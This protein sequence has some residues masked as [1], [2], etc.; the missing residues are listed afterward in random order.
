MERFRSDA[1]AEGDC[2]VIGGWE[3]RTALGITVDQ[4]DARWF[5]VELNRKNAPWA[6]RRGEPFRVIA[7]LELLGSLLSTVLFLGG[8]DGSDW[9]SGTISAG[10][11]TDNQGNRFVLNRM[12]TTKFP[13]LAFLCEFAT[14]LEE[15]G[16]VLDLAWVPRDQNA[17]ADAITNG[18]VEAFRPEN[19][20]HVDIEQMRFNV[21]TE[22][23]EL[24]D[25]FYEALEKDKA[26][27]K[28]AAE[29]E[30]RPRDE[31]AARQ[32]GGRQDG[33][34]PEEERKP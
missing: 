5:K 11:T 7:A 3:V 22:M 21:L 2:V 9:V 12:M 1:K 29:E 26:E 19:E 14:V 34:E 28:R 32:G 33:K 18:D 13:L 6:Y 23:L 17:E 10:L 31:G 20:V 4:K 24:G 8:R 30:K 15:R 25:G 16:C 27:R